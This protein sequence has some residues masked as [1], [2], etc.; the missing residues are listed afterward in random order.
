MTPKFMDFETDW[1]VIKENELNFLVKH[2][3]DRSETKN[4]AES[5]PPKDRRDEVLQILVNMAAFN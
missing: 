2:E 4:Q 1:E 3:A 5:I